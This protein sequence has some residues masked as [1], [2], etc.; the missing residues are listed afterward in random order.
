LRIKKE[1]PERVLYM[2]FFFS[3]SPKKEKRTGTRRE[4]KEEEVQQIGWTVEG[5]GTQ[6]KKE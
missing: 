6:Y 5:K 2:I 3:F 4:K 1:G